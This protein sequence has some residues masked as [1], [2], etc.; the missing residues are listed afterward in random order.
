MARSGEVCELLVSVA[1]TPLD[2]DP[3]LS[4]PGSP[5][6]YTEIPGARVEFIVTR[7]IRFWGLA[8]KLITEDPQ[9][10]QRA[11]GE[12]RAAIAVAY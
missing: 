10:S 7:S 1:E 3:G 8:A 5:V 6:R 4:I 2:V 12:L 11:G 9:R